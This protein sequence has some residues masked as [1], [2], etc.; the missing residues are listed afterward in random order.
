MSSFPH[1]PSA[2]PR[3]RGGVNRRLAV[4]V[5]LSAAMWGVHSNAAPDDFYVGRTI[6]IITSGGGAYEAYGRTFARYMPKYIAGHPAMIV[7]AMPGAGG[8]RAASFL[9]KVA[10][11]DGTVIGALHGAVLTGPF[12]NPRAADFDVTRFSWIGNATR[13][14][15]VGYV[16]HT[17]PVQSLE[18]AK[19]RQ[20]VV[21]GTS[22]GGNGI[23]MA[24]IMK[25]IFGYK[26]KIVSGYKNSAETKLA[27]ERGEIEGTL[28]NAW[29]SLNQT[30]W[31]ARKLVRV[32]VQHG[33][34]KHRELPDVPL[35]KDLA[36]TQA[37]RQMIDLMNVRDEI[38]R[39]YVAPPDIPPAR[40][41]VL[42]RAFD[43]TV[44]DPAFLAE[45]QRQHLEVD[46]PST[47][48]ELTALVDTIAKTPP[49]VVQQLVTLF[50]NY[51]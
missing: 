30:D 36:R 4:C 29:S 25:E 20:F 8:A 16:W 38:T 14:K 51:R 17:A 27:L 33:S 15:F 2:F 43:G 10:P 12:L 44:S 5:L 39:P 28:A 41:E 7:Q 6:T 9:Y 45:M 48:Q 19:T 1:S 31:L 32:I 3:N 21:G 26:L 13:D 49:A 24:I 18:Q 34:Q 46:G 42:R 50:A 22:L 35:F 40:L 37:E 11:R 23:D 47:G